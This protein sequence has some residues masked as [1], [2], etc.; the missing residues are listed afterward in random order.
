MYD[1]ALQDVH[2]VESASREEFYACKVPVPL[3][4]YIYF[5]FLMVAFL[6]NKT[7]LEYYPMYVSSQ[8]YIMHLNNRTVLRSFN[9]IL[10]FFFKAI[11]PKHI[12]YIFMY[13]FL[14][15]NAIK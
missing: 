2:V 5:I 11:L 15:F 7:P 6:K 14:F 13:L 10:F 3:L 4:L 8:Q 1:S 9:F 12:V